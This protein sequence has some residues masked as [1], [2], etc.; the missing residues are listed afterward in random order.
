MKELD[1]HLREQNGQGQQD[2]GDPRTREVSG[3]ILDDPTIKIKR[4]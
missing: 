1:K 3:D 4:Q 2:D